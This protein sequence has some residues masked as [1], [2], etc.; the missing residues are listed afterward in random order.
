MDG[1][2]F[3]ALAPIIWLVIALIGLK[4]PAWQA[5]AVALIFAFIMAM[6]FFGMP[7]RDTATAALEGATMA[8]WPII[9]VIISAIFTYNLS[10]FTKGIETIKEMLNSVSTDQRIIILLIAWGFGGFLECMSGFGTAV[11]I[12]ASML[13]SIGINPISAIIVCLLANAVQS[14]YGSIGLPLITLAQL[15]NFDGS[16]IATFTT[17]QLSFMMIIMPFLMLVTFGGSLKALRGMIPAC[18]VAGLGFLVP[19]VVAGNFMGAGLA[20]V[21]GAIFSMGLIVAYAKMFPVK[22]EE[23]EVPTVESTSEIT[24]E[25]GLK[26]WL[27][28]ILIFVFLIVTSKLVPPVN[29]F[30]SQ[31]KTSIP[32][33][34]GE[35]AGLYTFTWIVTP[36]TLIMTSAII[37][38]FVQGATVSDMLS[39][40]HRTVNTLIPT[41]ITMIT[42]IATARV[43]GY[44]GM[45]TTM[46]EV[47]VAA[48]GTL[49]PAIS[50]LIGAAGSFIT[51][52]AT[53]S[54]VLF[55]KLQADAALA[56]GANEVGQA[57]MAAAN[58][59]GACVGKIISPQ[60]IAIG[61]AAVGLRGVESQ[62]MS[63]AIKVF[64]PFIILMGA[65][66][67]F[68]ESFVS[69][70][71]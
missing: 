27:P 1:L 38:G 65:I 12:G 43:M 14:S 22:D 44:S 68:G 4:L 18:L 62:I 46:A 69:A 37:S 41:F 57:W 5:C 49:Y 3:A 35:G 19:A 2:F 34:T 61:V 48:T 28:F 29:D 53:T 7:L 50:P 64:I 13:V 54:G 6:N 16:Q 39:V 15:T 30:L 45:I 10:V 25:K 33:Y 21:A 51:G 58:A 32:I 23:Y 24:F 52:S 42:I 36:G 31:F 71:L 56:I 55:G 11:A 17:L 66:V 26:A 47:T 8:V 70:I 40:L 9:W 67:Y 63:F 20:G 59:A 60:S